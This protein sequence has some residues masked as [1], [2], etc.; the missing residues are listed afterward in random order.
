MNFGDRVPEFIKSIWT[1][2]QGIHLGSLAAHGHT[3]KGIPYT[4]CFPMENS[5]EIYLIDPS[6]KQETTMLRVHDRQR[7]GDSQE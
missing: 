7:H 1:G 6:A 5:S 2:I 3:E 4:C